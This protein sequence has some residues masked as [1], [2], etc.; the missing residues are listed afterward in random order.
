MRQT[1]DEPPLRGLAFGLHISA[2]SVIGALLGIVTAFAVPFGPRVGVVQGP[3]GDEPTAP[4]QALAAV[5]SGSFGTLLSVG[6]VLAFFGVLLVGILARRA[7][8]SRLA[9]LG[10]ITGWLV[11]ALLALSEGPFGGDLVLPAMVTP[12]IAYLFAGVIGGSVTLLP[13]AILPAR[14]RTGPA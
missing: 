10:P 7:T 12:G 2:F 5:Q 4:A 14:R 3:I 9:P 1:R 8:G 6:V 11:I 13:S